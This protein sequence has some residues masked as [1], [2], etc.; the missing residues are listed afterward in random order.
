MAWGQGCNLSNFTSVT[1]IPATSYPFTSPSSGITVSATVSNTP[2]LSNT[3]Y[4]CNGQMFAMSSPAWWQNASTSIITLTFSVP[5]S[6]FTV[7]V[8][9]TNDTEEFSYFANSGTVM[10]SDY[11]ATGWTLMS[12]NTVRYGLGPA[13]GSIISINH[14]T[15]A[16]QFTLRH[17]GLGSGSRIGLLDCFVPAAVL[18]VTM[19]DFQASHVANMQLNRVEWQTSEEHGAQQFE[20]YHSLDGSDW[21]MIGKVDAHGNTDRL[22]GYTYA[23][24]LP[25]T[26]MNYYKLRTVDLDGNFVYSDT[27]E[28]MVQPA[29]GIAVFPNPASGRFQVLSTENRGELMVTDLA[30]KVLRRM[31]FQGESEVD[32]SGQP[33]GTYLVSLQESNGSRWVERVVLK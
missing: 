27:R 1:S 7:V 9:G 10:L 14:P 20:V 4:S 8:N 28:V 22:K 18:P 24:V 17:N 16:T 3:S 6:K 33:R 2:T 25:P 12:S 5:V 15:G 21:N 23:H 11:C 13:S 30:G 32:L 26:G 19:G 29:Q 31:P